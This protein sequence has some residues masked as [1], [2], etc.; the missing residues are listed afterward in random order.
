MLFAHRLPLIT[1]R[2]SGT[3]IAKEM[4]KQIMTLI[5]S[6]N[7][8]FLLIFPIVILLTTPLHPQTNDICVKTFRISGQAVNGAKKEIYFTGIRRY[9]D[10]SPQEIDEE[11]KSEESRYGDFRYTLIAEPTRMMDCAGYVMN[12][13]WKTRAFRIGADNF[14]TNI[15]R[16]FAIQI[17]NVTGW[18]NVKAGDIVV[19]E[20]NGI[21]NHIAYVR[22]VDT[23]VGFANCIIVETKDGDEGTY[24]HILPE[25]TTGSRSELLND[26]LIRVYGIP[27]IFRINPKLV[28]VSELHESECSEMISA[29]GLNKN[30]IGEWYMPGFKLILSERN[31]GIEMI[32]KQDRNSK[33]YENT[34]DQRKFSDVKFNNGIL[35]GRWDSDPLYEDNFLNKTGKGSGTF[36]LRLVKEEGSNHYFL[37]GTSIWDSEYCNGCMDRWV[38]RRK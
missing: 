24:T 31:G 15:I 2:S 33:K 1:V 9:K 7:I 36:E 21:G 18:G 3:K 11:I 6:G 4:S 8:F 5:M 10:F 27:R 29:G 37:K 32:Y 13:I 23:T 25:Y 38:W 19:Y 35:S 26:P 22:K 34:K 14:T 12:Q 20:K 30:W 17:S 16:N 28:T